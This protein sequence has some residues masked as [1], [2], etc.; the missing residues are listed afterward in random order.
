MKQVMSLSGVWQVVQI[1]RGDG[2]SRRHPP[3]SGSN[4]AVMVE[5]NGRMETGTRHRWP[6]V[7]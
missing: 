4:I 6:E 2:A 7:A 3:W 5:E 1:I